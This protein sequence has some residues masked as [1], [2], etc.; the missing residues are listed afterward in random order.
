MDQ[1]FGAKGC[2]PSHLLA[3]GVFVISKLWMCRVPVKKVLIRPVW[4]VCG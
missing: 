1:K 2:K 3:F 4:L